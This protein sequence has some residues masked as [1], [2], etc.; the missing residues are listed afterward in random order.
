MRRGEVRTDIKKGDL[1]TGECQ[2]RNCERSY[3]MFVY[4]TCL[5]IFHMAYLGLPSP[6]APAGVVGFALYPL[7]SA[8][9]GDS[10]GALHNVIVSC[11]HSPV[12]ICWSQ[13]Q[14]AVRK[15]W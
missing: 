6:D 12:L 1:F 4:P 3:C 14:T 15:S 8:G 5:G 13:A 10:G 9:Y 11:P 2:E 7:V